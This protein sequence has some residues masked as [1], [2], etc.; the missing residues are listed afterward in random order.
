MIEQKITS[1]QNSKIQ[2]ARSLKQK[3]LRD[4]LNRF[5]AEGDKVIADAMSAGLEISD[6]FV[7]DEKTDK[8]KDI[9]NQAAGKNV[10]INIVNEKVLS[11]ISQTKSPQGIVALIKKS[12]A[13]YSDNIFQKARFAAMLENLQ[14]PG[15][16]GTIIRT[17][18]AV[19]VDF[20]IM[21][22]CA[23]IYN[24]KVLRASM[25]SIF[26]V[27][28]YEKPIKECIGKMKSAGWQVG[29]GHL[30]GENFYMR[31][32]LQK[33]ALIIGNESQGISEITS[34]LCTDLWKLP[35]RGSADSL[36]ASVAAGIMLYD[37]QNK[38]EN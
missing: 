13:I 37:I 34:K 17:C 36:N 10:F 8:F 7:L 5:L 35:M 30:H 31:R 14:D 24:P 4:E 2:K 1:V 29:C 19:G 28:I 27:P 22:S 15:N 23:D 16:L 25:G 9:L 32:Q 3:K 21:E 26:N 6:I 20:I 33:A 38:F 12:E 18:D 11:S